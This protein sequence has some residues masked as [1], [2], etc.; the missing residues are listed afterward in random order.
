MFF[1]NSQ[2]NED[3]E[4]MMLWIQSS[5]ENFNNVNIKLMDQK[6]LKSVIF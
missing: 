3:G 6:F 4:L 1:G 5:F 2:I